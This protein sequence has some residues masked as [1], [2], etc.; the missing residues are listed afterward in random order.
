MLLLFETFSSI[1]LMMWLAVKKFKLP[2]VFIVGLCT[3]LY[4]SLN[5]RRTEVLDKPAVQEIVGGPLRYVALM[6]VTRSRMH[7]KRQTLNVKTGSHIYT[8]VNMIEQARGAMAGGKKL[9]SAPI[10][11]MKSSLLSY[12]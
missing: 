12:L 3:I 7:M 8:A 6:S 11:L 5:S 9:N 2:V 4:F 1:G 10:F